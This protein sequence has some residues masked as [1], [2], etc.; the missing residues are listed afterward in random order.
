LMMILTIS[1]PAS[2]FSLPIFHNAEQPKMNQKRC[3]R[4]ILN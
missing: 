1:V 3:G 4:F 2:G